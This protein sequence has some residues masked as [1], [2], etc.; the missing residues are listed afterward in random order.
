[1]SIA[2]EPR[3]QRLQ[4]RFPPAKC[5][6]C[7][8]W[9]LSVIRAVDTPDG[10]VITSR[11]LPAECPACGRDIPAAQLTRVPGGKRP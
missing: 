5:P 9:I 6:V 7:R 3:V 11:S 4:Q 1:M 8:D 2:L 10:P